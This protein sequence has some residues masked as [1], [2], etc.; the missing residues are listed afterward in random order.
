[1]KA[2][3]KIERKW[4]MAS[5]WT[6]S[7]KPI[8]DMLV[9]EMTKDL[10]IDPFAGKFSPASVTNDLN[11]EMETTHHMEALDFLKMYDDE[12]VGGV[13]LDPPYSP[14]QVSEC[15]KGFGKKVTSEMTRCDFYSKLKNEI[16]RILK[17]NGKVISFGWNS[18]GCG[19]N[20]GFTMTRVLLVPHGGNKN[21]TICT[22]ETKN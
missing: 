16:K 6:F 20:R 4:A 12:S 9:E 1:M 22:V 18:M 11:P 15:Y 7:I 3:T 13:L 19:L 10:W 2:I 5:R 14:R 21:D 8:K 17:P